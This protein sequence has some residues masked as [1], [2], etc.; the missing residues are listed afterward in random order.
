MYLGP[1]R[2]PGEGPCRF[3][4]V[5]TPGGGEGYFEDAEELARANERR[6]PASA[7]AALHERYALEYL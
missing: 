1:S 2:T 6:P 3:L 7:M 4:T 5:F